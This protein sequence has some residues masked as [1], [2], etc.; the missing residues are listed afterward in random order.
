MK[1]LF[2]KY[3]EVHTS[4]Q[5]SSSEKNKNVSFISAPILHRTLHEHSYFSSLFLTKIVLNISLLV[6]LFR[7]F[8]NFTL[9]KEKPDY[10]KAERATW[11]LKSYFQLGFS[12][13]VIKKSNFY[14]LS[15]QHF[16]IFT[17]RHA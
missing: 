2:N 10:L 9:T 7:E 13:S 4:S 6:K 17:F 14:K 3:T 1:L 16:S 15:A 5:K 11:N 12:S 8:Q